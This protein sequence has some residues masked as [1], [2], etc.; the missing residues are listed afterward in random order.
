MRCWCAMGKDR[1]CPEECPVGAYASLP[2]KEKRAKR[3]ALALE[4]H[5]KGMIQEQIAAELGVPRSTIR[6]DLLE[7][8]DS[9]KPHRPK[10]G[11]PKGAGKAPKPKPVGPQKHRRT[12]HVEAA[13]LVLDEG[14]TYEQA[15][16]RCDV[17]LQVVRASVQREE[18]RREGRADPDIDRAEL[19][20]SAQQ[21]LDAA[22][23]HYKRQLNLEF[24]QR[25]QDECKRWL[26]E[27]SLP[28]YVKEM[29]KLEYSISSRKGIM[30]KEVYRL[31]LS[32][33]HTDSRNSVS[34]KKLNEAFNEFKV[35][36]KRL[37]DEKESPT[38]FKPLPRTAAE[39]MAM[40]RKKF[41]FAR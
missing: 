41:N 30:S 11:R 12:D 9:A 39:M 10:G 36:E 18:G 38:E 16:E 2:P 1:D 23:R 40:R 34:D 6:D 3:K 15:A 31:I 14:L 37:L 29:A 19:S 35:R 26:E 13:R 4:L 22:L 5:H 32:C 24:E 7:F 27:C 33:L 25:V 17:S 20:L 8:G 28:A 21:K